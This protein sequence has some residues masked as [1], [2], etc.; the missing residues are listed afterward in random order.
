MKRIFPIV[1]CAFM[2]LASCQKKN[3]P[4][5]RGDY[6]F[7]TS[8]SVTA[9]RISASNP[10]AFEITLPNEIGQMEIA[11]L[12][13]KNDSVVVVMNYMKNEVIVTHGHCQGN[14]IVLNDFRR[15]ALKLSMD[16]N[17]EMTCEVNVRARGTMY[18]E[19]TLVLNVTYRGEAALGGLKY[20]IKGD[21]IQTV[22]TR[23]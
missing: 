10:T 1:I 19:N 15:N 16:G 13:R 22:A 21:N 6:S 12:D 18:D 9:Q 17:L 23:N 2:A 20:N 8:G 4:L 7:K 14:D 3:A 5:F 11:L